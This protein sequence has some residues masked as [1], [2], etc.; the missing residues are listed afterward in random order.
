M[1]F[2]YSPVFR[3][4]T[5]NNTQ[6]PNTPAELITTNTQTNTNID[7]LLSVEGVGVKKH[8]WMNRKTL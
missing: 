4:N 1:F 5:N 3:M 7:Q 6:L 2:P 8:E